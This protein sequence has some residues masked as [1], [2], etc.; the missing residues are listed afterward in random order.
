[1]KSMKRIVVFLVIG[2]VLI[3]CGPSESEIA[4]SE[5]ETQAAI[6]ALA[7]EVA[8]T[9]QAIEDAEKTTTAEFNQGATKTANIQLAGTQRAATAAAE[10]VAQTEV[11][12]SMYDAIVELAAYDYIS[13][14][15]GE[16]YQLEDF[17]ESWAQLG[18]YIWWP[19]Y[20]YPTDFVVRADFEW[21]SAS[22]T[23]DWFASGCGFLFRVTDDDD[24]YL[25]LLALDGNVVFARNY[26]DDFKILGRSWYGNLDTPSGGAQVMLIVEDDSFTFFVNDER[27]R[28]QVDATLKAGDLAL[29]L[30][31][32][33]NAGFGTSCKI[34]N[35]E[36][37]ILD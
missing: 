34:Q 13:T 27:V 22:E 3:G 14:D 9:Q 17:S 36:L 32:G 6:D 25:V 12:S 28:T 20:T 33:T 23:S 35:L 10:V 4:T 18:W 19:T 37:W 7:T 31:S 1:M 30:V 29:T 15:A 24:H 8:G 5:A 2:I 21:D 26:R 16:Y 11:A